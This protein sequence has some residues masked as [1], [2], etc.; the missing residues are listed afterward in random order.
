MRRHLII[1]A[2]DFG[3]TRGI[4][5]AVSEC[6][7]FGM[8][9][10]ATLIANGEA[11]DD[12]VKVAKEQEGLGTGIHFVL[13][14]FKPLLPAEKLSGFVSADGFMPS[15]PYE[16]LIE[17]AVRKTLPDV[18]RK[19]LFAQAERVFDAGIT[20]THFDSHKHVHIIPAVL[21]ILIEIAQRFSVRWIREP[22][23]AAGAWRFLCD[24][25]KG[26]GAGFVKQFT[27][28]RATIAARPIF[29]RRIREAGIQT[30]AGLYGI[31]STGLINEKI[32]ER[33]CRMLK[34]GLSELMTHPGIVDADLVGRKSRLIDSRAR[35]RDLLVSTKVKELF[36]EREITLS[37]FGEV[38]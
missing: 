9:R 1:N 33:I 15:G 24:L 19:E 28:A 8:L 5:L 27:K 12:A 22:F 21:D 14:G 32:I 3:M 37:H 35:E 13:T 23:E 20:P 29:R 17:F 2:D 31:S 18:I 7:G 36:R 30:P 25:E 38:I 16:L 34:P 11:F 6:A 26:L 10:S 4:N